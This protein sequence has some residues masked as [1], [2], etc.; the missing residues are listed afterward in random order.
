ME[1]KGTRGFTTIAKSMSKFIVVTFFTD[2]QIGHDP[3]HLT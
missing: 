1:A 2:N 3:G